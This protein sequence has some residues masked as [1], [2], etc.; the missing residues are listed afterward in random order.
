M[1]AGW[2]SRRIGWNDIPREDYR[3]FRADLPPGQYTVDFQSAT[4]LRPVDFVIPPG[5]GRLTLPELRVESLAY[6][7]MLGKPALELEAVDLEGKPARLA[8][9]RGKVVLLYLWT[10]WHDEEDKAPAQLI[11]L[12]KRFNGQPLVI[13]AVHDASITSLKVYKETLAP[14]LKENFKQ[15]ER[16]FLP[17]LDQP[18]PV[19]RGTGPFGRHAGEQGSGLTIG[20][21]EAVHPTTLIIDRDGILTFVLAE[22]GG[23]LG[24]QVFRIGQ[25]GKLAHSTMDGRRGESDG[26]L[27]TVFASNELV[28]ALEDQLGL[29]RSPKREPRDMFADPAPLAFKGPLVVSGSVIDR[30]GKPVVGAKV[31]LTNM[32]IREREVTTKPA[33]EFSFTVESIGWGTSLE[34][35]APGMPTKAFYLN[36]DA[37]NAYRHLDPENARDDDDSAYS[38]KVDPGGR[39]LK[40]LQ[41][42]RDPAVTGRVVRAGKPVSGVTMVVDRHAARP[43]DPFDLQG[44]KQW[45][46]ARIPDGPWLERRLKNL[47]A[48]SDAQGYF[49]IGDLLAEQEWI[50]YAKA[51][52]LPDHQT[53]VPRAFKTQQ[54]GKNIDLGELELRPGRALAGRVV[55][56]DGGAPVPGTKMAI[57][58]QEVVELWADLDTAGR[59]EFKGVL[60]GPLTIRLMLKP[61]DKAS[62]A[63]PPMYRLSPKNKCL[64]PEQPNHLE[65]TITTDISNL[66]ILLE[67]G[68]EPEAASVVAFGVDPALVADFQAAKAGPI[69]GVPPGD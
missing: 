65:G 30:D 24:D 52:S 62:P 55:L 19:G 54:E 43:T 12:H 64:D 47:Q 48:T 34:I 57:R 35:D 63:D 9:Y 22:D 18:P 20:R 11:D 21:Y 45:E 4:V 1:F 14:I 42:G 33:G 68:V 27:R 15:I 61:N 58:S 59:F 25:D 23:G 53:L 49:H 28:A 46:P 44:S 60:D 16:P 67:P 56:A 31:L 38:R 3:R 37:Q 40:P 69:T 66:T 39:I 29:P 7:N 13:L 6:V 2:T 5:E 32:K 8:D 26:N 36:F 10:I 50:I 17:L 51:G 41:L